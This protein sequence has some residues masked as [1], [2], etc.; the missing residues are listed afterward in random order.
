MTARRQAP[1][2]VLVDAAR[3]KRT[4]QTLS[5]Y[6]LHHDVGRVVRIKHGTDLDNVGV[7]EIREGLCLGDKSFQPPRICFE[8]RIDTATWGIQHY[9]ISI[10]LL[11]HR[12]VQR[13]HCI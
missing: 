3:F 1:A 4:L 9:T 8:S 5:R 13:F 10:Q 2:R 7:P 12:L 11:L 6:V